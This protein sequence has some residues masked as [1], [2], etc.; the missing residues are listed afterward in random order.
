[1]KD[2]NNS[3]QLGTI[4]KIISIYNPAYLNLTIKLRR[5][6]FSSGKLGYECAIIY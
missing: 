6:L 1:M 3:N 5:L 2:I 4:F